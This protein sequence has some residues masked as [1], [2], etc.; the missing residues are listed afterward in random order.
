MEEIAS[1]AALLCNDKGA[2]F[3]HDRPGVG[4]VG[5][6]GRGCPKT[7]VSEGAAAVE[8]ASNARAFSQR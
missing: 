1:V 3:R 6:D 2:R 8:I 4:T 7:W 5:G